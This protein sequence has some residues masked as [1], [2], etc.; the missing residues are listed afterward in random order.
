MSVGKLPETDGPQDKKP[1]SI[2]VKVVKS[3]DEASASSLEAFHELSSTLTAPHEMPS[4]VVLIREPSRAAAVRRVYNVGCLFCFPF[5]RQGDLITFQRFLLKEIKKETSIV[6]LKRLIDD[7]IEDKEHIQAVFRLHHRQ[8]ELNLLLLQLKADFAAI[9]TGFTDLDVIQALAIKYQVDLKEK[10]R[11]L[12]TFLENLETVTASAILNRIGFHPIQVETLSR[13]FRLEKTLKSSGFQAGMMEE[14]ET[15]LTINS[16]RLT[17]KQVEGLLTPIGLEGVY[18]P[19]KVKKVTFAEETS[20]LEIESRKEVLDSIIAKLKR[21][22]ID[23]LALVE[24]ALEGV[25]KIL[26]LEMPILKMDDFTTST[27][28]AIARYCL[29]FEGYSRAERMAIIE[30][31]PK[32]VLAK[33]A[34]IEAFETRPQKEV[35]YPIEGGRWHILHLAKP[36]AIRTLGRGTRVIHSTIFAHEVPKKDMEALIVKLKNLFDL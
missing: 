15:I 5:A 33:L 30:G 28:V 23:D 29:Y 21:P 17:I 10:K 24:L 11:S 4:G 35:R 12:K 25:R 16:Y 2:E 19:P 3:N 26:G 18:R 9:E 32:K 31:E 8:D 14:I 13:I 22:R 20:V 7:F 36:V 34:E 6:S 1:D 27:Q